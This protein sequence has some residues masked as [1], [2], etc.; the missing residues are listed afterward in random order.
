MLSARYEV[1]K[2]SNFTSQLDMYPFGMSGS[3]TQMHAVM[4]F[5]LFT[6]LRTIFLVGCDSSNNGYAKRMKFRKRGKQKFQNA[7]KG[8]KLMALFIK[9][10]YPNTSIIIH[11]PV[12][13]TAMREHGWKLSFGQFIPMP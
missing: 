13:L 9:R 10:E 1:D 3:T 6:G 2:S 5:L 12:G 8:W 11:N 7:E 4:Q